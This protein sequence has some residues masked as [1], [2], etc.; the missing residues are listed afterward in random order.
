MKLPAIAIVTAF[1]AGI[2]IGYWPLL[3]QAELSSF[4]VACFITAA[5]FLAAAGFLVQ[6]SLR[7]GGLLS[8]VAWMAFGISGAAIALQPKPANQVLHLLESSAFDSTTPLR[9][10]GKLRTGKVSK[11]LASLPARKSLPY[12][13]QTGR[14][15]QITNKTKSNNRNPTAA[16]Y[17]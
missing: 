9:W 5:S 15:C 16:S 2:A 8:L 10:H 4:H 1:A 17:S 13:I 12:S 6:R 11:C 7:V 14:K 3:R